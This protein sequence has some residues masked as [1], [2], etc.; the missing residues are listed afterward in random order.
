MTTEEFIV[1]HHLFI[2]KTYS[3]RPK[4]LDQ[5]IKQVH[6]KE[7]I[8]LN[9]ANKKVPAD[10]VFTLFKNKKDQLPVLNILTADCLPIALMSINGMALIHAGWKGLKLSI[11][12]NPVLSQIKPTEAFLGPHIGKCCYQVSKEFFD[13]FPKTTPYFP[14]KGSPPHFCL[15]SEAISQLKSTF[16]EIKIRTS[17]TCTMCC[18]SLNSYRRDK[19]AQRNWNT[20]EK[21]PL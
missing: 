10:G 2:F 14:K 13:N 5:Q 1:D 15:K 17:T 16:P 4:D 11:L 12:K 21:R 18:P 8:S 19:T 7:V 20:L 3:S 9:E 6:G